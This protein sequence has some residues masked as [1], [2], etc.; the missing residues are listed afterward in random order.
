MMNANNNANRKA[1]NKVLNIK[2]RNWVEVLLDFLGLELQT[3]RCRD[4]LLVQRP[5]LFKKLV[6]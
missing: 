6:V 1:A 3:L 5:G 2:A 4:D